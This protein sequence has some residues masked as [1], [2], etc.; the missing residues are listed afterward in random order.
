M[1]AWRGC[2]LAMSVTCIV[3]S[4]GVASAKIDPPTLA[5]PETATVSSH[6]APVPAAS[7]RVTFFDRADPR[8]TALVAP[9]RRSLEFELTL[10]EAN[11]RIYITPYEPLT[12]RRNGRIPAQV[13]AFDED[14]FTEITVSGWLSP[15]WLVLRVTLSG[16]DANCSRHQTVRLHRPVQ[17]TPRARY[18]RRAEGARAL[19][20]A[21]GRRVRFEFW[22]TPS[23]RSSTTLR[24]LRLRRD[25]SVAG[26]RSGRRGE[27]VTATGFL[28]DRG[29]LIVAVEISRTDDT[30]APGKVLLF[31]LRRGR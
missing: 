11:C 3:A 30:E 23:S 28:L 4:A 31:D 1:S 10:G 2:L 8:N 9:N 20:S 24:P 17:L 5:R 19:V 21:N 7:R 22:R 18:G 16:Y 6:G 25:G 26:F 15:R 27:T 12:V 14:V 29:R 13:V